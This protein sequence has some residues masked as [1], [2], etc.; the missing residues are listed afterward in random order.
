MKNKTKLLL[1]EAYEYCED[2][3][4]SAEFLIEYLQDFANVDLDRVMNYL[5]KYHNNE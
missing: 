1:D 4:K 2:N 3:D 5:F